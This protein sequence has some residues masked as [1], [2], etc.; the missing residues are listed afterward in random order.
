MFLQATATDGTV[1]M[2][3]Q[4]NRASQEGRTVGFDEE[5]SCQLE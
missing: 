5:H 4:T 2:H 3:K 1:F